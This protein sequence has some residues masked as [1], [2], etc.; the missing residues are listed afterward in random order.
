MIAFM[1][2]ANPFRRPGES[3]QKTGRRFE[4]FWAKFFGKEPTKGSG[5]LW[6]MPLDLSFAVFHFSLK[7]SDKDRL[8][9]G[10]HPLKDLL[11]E[12]DKAREDD[13]DIGLVA[14]FGQDDGEVYVTMRGTDFLRM[15]QSDQIQYMTPSHGEQKRLRAKI[16]SLLRKEDD[17]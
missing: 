15:V 11:N 10:S 4:V 13:G 9:F 1:E 5:N 3:H 16:P 2:R 6:Y 7:Y 17:G 14:T 12:A 8:R